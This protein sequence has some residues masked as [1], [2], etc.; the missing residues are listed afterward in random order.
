MD[1]EKLKSSKQNTVLAYVVF[2]E[3][4]LGYLYRLGNHFYIGVLHG[5]TIKGGLDWKGDDW[6]LG[7]DQFKDVRKATKEDF[8]DYNV[9]SKGHLT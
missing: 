8:D 4:T 2:R 6:L 5:K 9:S 3:H 1:F 7:I